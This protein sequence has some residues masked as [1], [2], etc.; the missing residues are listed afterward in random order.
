MTI[1]TIFTEAG[2]SLRLRNEALL[3][4]PCTAILCSSWHTGG[5]LSFQLPSAVPS[6]AVVYIPWKRSRT[7]TWLD[8]LKMTKNLPKD[9]KVARHFTILKSFPLILTVCLQLQNVI[10]CA[11]CSSSAQPAGR[12]KSSLGWPRLCE[13][14][15]ASLSPRIS[16]RVRR[17]DSEPAS[18]RMTFCQLLSC[19]S[20]PLLKLQTLRVQ[21]LL[22][23]TGFQMWISEK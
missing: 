7:L 22:I 9:K 11:A 1:V 8:L 10:H 14:L 16:E 23:S 15:L 19:D 12:Q 21:T 18:K 13:L 3:L 2:E 6:Q 4:L 20:H 5:S 17:V